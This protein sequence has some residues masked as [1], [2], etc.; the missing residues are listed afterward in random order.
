LG[1]QLIINILK[2]YL[3]ISCSEVKDVDLLSAIC[4][5]TTGNDK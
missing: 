5:D 4:I 1:I 2:R 3:L